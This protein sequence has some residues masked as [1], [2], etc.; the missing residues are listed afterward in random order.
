LSWTLQA[1]F[2]AVLAASV[3]WPCYASDAKRVR[4]F[5][6]GV[7]LLIKRRLCRLPRPPCSRDPV[8]S[9]CTLERWDKTA[10]VTLDR[11]VLQ[12]LCTLRFIAAHRNVV[13]LGPVGVGKTFLASALG[14][15]GTGRRKPRRFRCGQRDREPARQDALGQETAHL[16]LRHP[17][18]PTLAIPRFSTAAS[19]LAHSFGRSRRRRGLAVMASPR[20]RRRS[21]AAARGCTDRNSPQPALA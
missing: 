7:I 13:I 3:G 2:G 11:R 1:K 19:T 15:L 14:H 17:A 16:R 8:W 6:K 10:K 21:C 4:S 5:N 9:S 20:P 18:Q 12:E